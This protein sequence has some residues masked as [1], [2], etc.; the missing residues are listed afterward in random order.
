M[1]EW[2]KDVAH[3]MPHI[4]KEL[5]CPVSLENIILIDD[6]PEK[7]RDCPGHGTSVRGQTLPRRPNSPRPKSVLLGL[8]CASRDNPSLMRSAPGLFFF[9]GSTA[10]CVR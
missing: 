7:T 6:T 10:L 3:L 2:K 1:Y 9:I 5:Q 4:T 8:T